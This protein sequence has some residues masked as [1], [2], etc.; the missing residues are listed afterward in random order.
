[1]C[2]RI[3]IIAENSIKYIEIIID[4]WNMGNTVVLIDFK[5]P[6]QSCLE[7]M[8]KACVQK[9]YTDR[10]ELFDYVKKMSNIEVEMMASMEKSVCELPESI[11]KKYKVSHRKEEGVILFSSGTTGKSKGIILSH[12]SFTKNAEMCAEQ[13]GVN[14]NSTLY[15]YKTIS[16]CA[17]F[18]GEFMIALITG[19]KLYIAST[20]ILMRKHLNNINIYSVTHFSANPSVL[21]LISKYTN[22]NMEFPSLKL[23]VSSGSMFTRKCKLQAQDFFK[24]PIINMYG[25]TEISGLATSQIPLFSNKTCC[26]GIEQESVGTPLEGVKIKILGQKY[27]ELKKGE[28]GNIYISIPTVMIGYVEAETIRLYEDEYWFTGDKVL[29]MKTMNYS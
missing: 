16:H 26:S 19:A 14:K 5:I 29:S 18:V 17:S 15:L 28:I 24:C 12:Y 20:K 2:K 21:N 23:I 25:M 9:V 7:L 4:A 11:R 22:R 1:M 27:E 8:G 13:K 10:K 6:A 3:A